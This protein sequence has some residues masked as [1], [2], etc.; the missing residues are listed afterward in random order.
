M[1][2]LGNHAKMTVEI[3]RHKIRFHD[4]ETINNKYYGKTESKN[5][6]SKWTKS[7]SRTEVRKRSWKP[8]TKDYK[9][10]TKSR[11]G[12]LGLIIRITF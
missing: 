9:K 8:S 2:E 1:I 4:Y 10:V 12:M 11:A 7:I 3:S 5:S 6:S